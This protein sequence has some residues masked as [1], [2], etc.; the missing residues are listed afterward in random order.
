MRRYPD[1]LHGPLN[2]DK[3]EPPLMV[4]FLNDFTPSYNI[5]APRAFSSK[6]LFFYN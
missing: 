2:V 4:D 6:L 1:C 5:R 3:W